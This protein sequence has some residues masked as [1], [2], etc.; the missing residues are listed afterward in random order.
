MTADEKKEIEDRI[1]LATEIERRIRYLEEAMKRF[2]ESKIAYLLMP[3]SA[4]AG[5]HYRDESQ[6]P[7][8]FSRVCWSDDEPDLG[9]EIRQHLKDSISRR[10]EAAR[11]EYAKL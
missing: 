1:K 5:L 11:A 10:L 4:G 6:P 9:N 8:G 7:T 3:T 2:D